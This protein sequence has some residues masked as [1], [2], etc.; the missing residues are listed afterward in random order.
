MIEE[1]RRRKI[2]SSHNCKVEV[3]SNTVKE[4]REVNKG[5]EFTE[6]Q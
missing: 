5:R 4:K 6:A 2:V 3:R 1:E